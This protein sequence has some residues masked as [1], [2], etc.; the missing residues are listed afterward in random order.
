[1]CNDT[2]PP[3]IQFARRSNGSRGS[4]D[5]K[6]AELSLAFNRRLESKNNAL[7]KAEQFLQELKPTDPVSN[8]PGPTA[9][10]AVKQGVSGRGVFA[11]EPLRAGSALIR[12]SGPILRYAQTT[13]QTLAVQ[14]GPDEYLGASGGLDDFVN[15]CC[16]PNAGMKIAG[17]D[18][19]LIAI[20]DISPGEQITFDYST[21]MDEDDFEF[22]CL[23][24]SP[25]CRGRIRDFKHLP[26][27]LKR[28]YAALGVVPV[29]NQKYLI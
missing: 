7:S 13:P 9:K 22:D 3:R 1:L 5:A 28:K 23:C 24:G 20:R 6:V 27:E 2:D 12:Y 25:V 14:I 26:A 18:V 21:T 17:T 29:Y 15:H 8:D 10:L 16:D 4:D 19:Q 11:V